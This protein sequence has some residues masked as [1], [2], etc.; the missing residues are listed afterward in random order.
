MNRSKRALAATSFLGISVVAVASIALG[1]GCELI[2]HLDRSLADA[3]SEDVVLGACPICSSAE[4]GGPDAE[5]SIDGGDAG[6]W[7]AD[8]GPEMAKD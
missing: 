4:D 3:G 2:V 8:A 5:A 1:S 6:A 7:D